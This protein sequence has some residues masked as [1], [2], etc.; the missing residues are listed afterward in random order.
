MCDFIFEFRRWN[1]DEWSIVR[2]SVQNAR[3]FSPEADLPLWHFLVNGS[4]LDP[5]K[6]NCSW[7]CESPCFLFFFCFLGC[8]CEFKCVAL[9]LANA[10]W[11]HRPIIVFMLLWSEVNV[12]FGMTLLLILQR[13]DYNL[14]F[15]QAG[16]PESHSRGYLCWDFSFPI[17]HTSS[18]CISSFEAKLF[19]HVCAQYCWNLSRTGTSGS[20]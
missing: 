17:C 12:C 20:R 1:S 6:L 11:H 5:S 10:P 9:Y 16:T 8:V 2:G 14:T 18:R 13:V 3:V 19:L 7:V 4:C 15:H